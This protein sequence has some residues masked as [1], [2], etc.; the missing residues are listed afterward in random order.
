MK[1]MHE[2]K[3]K[4]VKE[5][6]LCVLLSL[7]SFCGYAGNCDKVEDEVEHIN[8]VVH[9]MFDNLIK[10]TTTKGYAA[11]TATIVFMYGKLIGSGSAIAANGDEDVCFEWF[12]AKH[13][14]DVEILKIVGKGS[15]KSNKK[16]GKK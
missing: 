10:P 6:T 16:G 9:E 2:N 3:M 14:V 15:N 8:G 1:T 11:V 5:I 7:L 12:K 13:M 4:Y